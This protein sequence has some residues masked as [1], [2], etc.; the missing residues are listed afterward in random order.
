MK[1]VKLRVDFATGKRAGN[2]NPKSTNNR[3]CS[4]WQDLEN[5]F[6]MRLVPDD[7]AEKLRGA[8]GVTVFD[9]AEDAE[10]E[11]AKSFPEKV[12]WKVTNEALL[13]YSLQQLKPDLSRLSRDATADEELEF[14]HKAGVHG[15]KKITKTRTKAKDMHAA[16]ESQKVKGR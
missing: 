16:L 3:C 6:E 10:A 14:L 1:A 4:T 9:S 5:G 11:L 13:V 7:E 12:S 2:V 8:E 15:I